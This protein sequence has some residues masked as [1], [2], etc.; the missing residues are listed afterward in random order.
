MPRRNP[1]LHVL[2]APLVHPVQ[3][4]RP[5]L[6]RCGDPQTRHALDTEDG[7]GANTGKCSV[8][9]CGC[10]MFRQEGVGGDGERG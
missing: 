1:W 6:C 5:A 3:G 2:P 4:E 7:D 9:S 8:R 10:R